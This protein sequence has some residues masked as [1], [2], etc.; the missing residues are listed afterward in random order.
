M[1]S[2]YL[3]VYPVHTCMEGNDINFHIMAFNSLVPLSVKDKLN[4]QW[5]Y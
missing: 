5:I 4:A 2:T 1:F 3:T